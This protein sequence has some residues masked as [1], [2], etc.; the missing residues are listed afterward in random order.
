MNI[1]QL[2]EMIVNGVACDGCGA[3]ETLG[4]CGTWAFGCPMARD[5]RDLYALMDDFG[6][7]EKDIVDYVKNHEKFVNR[8]DDE[9]AERFMPCPDD[10]GI[11]PEPDPDPDPEDIVLSV[12]SQISNKYLNGS[13]RRTIHRM[14]RTL[15]DIMVW[16]D[17]KDKENYDSIKND[18]IYLEYFII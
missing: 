8:L 10:W 2:T 15:S 12:A 18:P 17:P 7:Q 9:Y 5:E 4:H 6:I 1:V 16:D 3:Y 14:L 11:I 13:T